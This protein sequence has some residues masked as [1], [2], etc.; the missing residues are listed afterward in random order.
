M[1][2]KEIELQKAKSFFVLAQLFMILSGFLFAGAGIALTNAQT[3][4]KTGID[5][6][7]YSASLAN[8]EILNLPQIKS[9]NLTENYTTVINSFASMSKSMADVSDANTNYSNRSFFGGIV[10]AILSLLSYLFGNYK[11]SKIKIE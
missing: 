6:E 7:Y 11:L 8:F 4:L 9:Y 2:K 10:F 5:S 3:N 1:D